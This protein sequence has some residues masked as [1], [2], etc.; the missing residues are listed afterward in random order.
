MVTIVC[1]ECKKEISEESFYLKRKGGNIY[2]PCKEYHKANQRRW[3]KSNPEKTHRR[4]LRDL[5]GITLED[6]QKVFAEQGGACK[7]CRK[8]QS[9]MKKA[10]C[11]D[12][13]HTTGEIRGLLCVKCNRAVG[14]LMDS[15][16]LAQ[17]LEAYL[18]T[19]TTGLKVVK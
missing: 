12:H 14:C 9:S 7:I 8:H 3:N 5:Y 10:L 18:K 15:P 1:R 19:S 6:W 16:D 2:Q 13:S 4:H 11:V 17:K